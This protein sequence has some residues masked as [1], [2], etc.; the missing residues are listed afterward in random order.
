[1]RKIIKCGKSLRNATFVIRFITT[2]TTTSRITSNGQS[3]PEFSYRYREW[4]LAIDIVDVNEY[5]NPSRVFARTRRG[6]DIRSFLS[7]LR[8]RGSRKR[9][10][11]RSA[12]N[13][14]KR[15][16]RSRVPDCET[17]LFLIISCVHFARFHSH[18]TSARAI[19][20][21]MSRRAEPRYST[22]TRATRKQWARKEGAAFKR[23]DFDLCFVYS[24]EIGDRTRSKCDIHDRF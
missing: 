13:I 15:T 22:M 10:S 12:L 9:G 23:I 17:F 7:A 21:G 16:A 2:I 3:A 14:A 19:R 4:N 11:P 1:M 20:R 8:E 6:T 18:G 5:E 24:R